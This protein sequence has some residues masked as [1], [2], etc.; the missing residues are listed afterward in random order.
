MS[1][2][3]GM[4]RLDSTREVFENIVGLCRSKKIPLLIDADGLFFVA[5]NPDIIKHYPKPVVLT[6]NKMEFKRI[7]GESQPDGSKVQQAQQFL[8]RVGPNVTIFCKDVVDE[9]ITLGSS[10]LV[11][12]ACLFC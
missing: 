8:E 4:G 5:Q 12:T 6:P 10:I 11:S 9:I 3:P 7:V 2:G 1:A